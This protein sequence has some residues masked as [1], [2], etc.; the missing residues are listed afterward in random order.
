MNVPDVPA[1]GGT[2]TRSVHDRLLDAAETC[3]RRDGIRRT[4]VAGIAEAAGVSRTWLYQHFAGKPAILGAALVRLDE[5]FWAEAHK[6]VGARRSFP[7]KVAEA[8]LIARSSELGPLAL[9]LRAREPDEF[10]ALMGRFVR[11][12]LPGMVPFWHLH[13]AAARDKGELRADLDIAGA[14]EWVLRVVVSLVTMPGE[15]VDPDDRR[16]LTRYLTTYLMPALTKE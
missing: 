13:L 9:E 7:A 14:A 8:I 12:S 15:V 6:R 11:D 10:E 16:A 4:T 3:L 2:E 5:A 1:Q